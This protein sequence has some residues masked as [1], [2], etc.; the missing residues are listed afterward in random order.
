MNFTNMKRTAAVTALV[1]AAL[2]SLPCVSLAAGTTEIQPTGGSY[3]GGTESDPAV[4]M[5]P[6][7]G[8]EL[9]GDI[10]IESGHAVIDM[11][12]NTLSIG[13]VH[14]IVSSGAALTIKDSSAAQTGCFDGQY[15]VKYVKIY[16]DYISD[17]IINHGELIIESG[18]FTDFYG[19]Y[20]SP[21][22]IRNYGVC[23]MNGG[24]M[25]NNHSVG[26]SNGTDAVFNMNGGV[27]KDGSTG[28]RNTGV[29][30]MSGGEISG[31]NNS[32]VINF[33]VFNM[34]GGV[35]KNS[36]ASCGGGVYNTPDG[37]FYMYGG[38]IC[39]N[40]AGWYGAGVTVYNEM[41]MYGGSI[42]DN[43]AVGTSY[44][45][46]GIYVMDG[47]LT[48]SGGA[49]TD[50][51]AVRE[52]GGVAIQ[53]GTVILNEGEIS[54]NSAERGGGVHI[55]SQ[56]GTPGLLIMNGGTITANTVSKDGAGVL[57]EYYESTTGYIIYGGGDMHM[58]GGTITGNKADGRG[59][60]IAFYLGKYQ[61]GT[62][63]PGGVFRY[64]GGVIEG[65]DEAFYHD[66][67][68]MILSV[69]GGLFEHKVFLDNGY[70]IENAIGADSDVVLKDI[71][72]EDPY[73][74]RIVIA[75]DETPGSDQLANYTL[76][77]DIAY[78]F[79]L[80]IDG[81]NIV[82]A[83]PEDPVAR[84]TVSYLAGTD[85]AAVSGLP[86]SDTV[87]G[88]SVYTVS[89]V[90]PVRKGYE[91]VCW[92]LDNAC[93]DTCSI[94]YKV[95]GDPVYG[96]PSDAVIPEDR[97]GC[98][99]GTYIWLGDKPET[100][101][102]TSDGSPLAETA[103]YTVNF[104]DLNT[105]EPLPGIEPKTVDGVEIGT[106]IR[107]NAEKIA[108]YYADDYELYYG[109]T[110]TVAINRTGTWTFT[111]W[112]TDE[113]CTKPV[114]SITLSGDHTVYGK[115]EYT[116][117]VNDN[118]IDFHYEKIPEYVSYTVEYLELAT[119]GP[120]EKAKLVKAVKYGTH[121]TETPIPIERYECV[122]DP[123]EWD[124]EGRECI[125]FY[126]VSK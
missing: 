107:L 53:Q 37:I 7:G 99:P 3:A 25:D 85:D 103:S 22:V 40:S 8:A 74:G 93:L 42:H 117:I 24:L 114:R 100:S 97:T 39:G 38:E 115:W 54:G 63:L 94:S 118:A 104:I 36:S 19:Q 64:F 86:Q 13:N 123:Y 79:V 81:N 66:G 28:V 51:T 43:H 88:S 90:T 109:K 89:S 47:T 78:S 126:Y 33:T 68:N 23:T 41:Y 57:S 10:I 91:F 59:D 61:E 26:V 2:L 6:E 32:G 30:S 102:K 35:I 12:G 11:A 17:F 16:K 55:S 31:M 95:I 83:Y 44:G 73:A 121:V 45:G 62:D 122:S 120:L 18:R 71:D 52:G 125:V 76:D 108:G 77:P 5:I 29:F 56:V 67:S 48:V 9:N 112:C 4:L 87:T 113:A 110:L 65:E 14:I 75:Y 60:G 58:Y 69:N 72:M 46:G 106:E 101:W 84:Y 20:S 15:S 119:G 82:L 92:I 96:A 50:N 98:L 116:E 1:L 80:K 49:I 105:G 21:G 27:I 70:Y 111:G 124:V 34:N